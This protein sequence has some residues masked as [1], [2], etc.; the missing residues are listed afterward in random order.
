MAD[1]S[2]RRR[3]M[4]RTPVIGTLTDHEYFVLE[5]EEPYIPELRPW[6][7]QKDGEAEE[8]ENEDGEQEGGQEAQS[9]AE[10]P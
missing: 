7:L 2:E 1:S 3:P 5:G 8:E 6:K 4:N 9:D 10:L